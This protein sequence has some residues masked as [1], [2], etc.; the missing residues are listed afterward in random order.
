MP[1][2][3]FEPTI[4]A[5][6][7]SQTYA[8]DRAATGTG[9]IRQIWSKISGILEDKILVICTG[10]DKINTREPAYSGTARDRKLFRC[11]RGTFRKRTCSLDLYTTPDIQDSIRFRLRQVFHWGISGIRSCVAEL[12][13]SVF[14]NYTLRKIPKE[15]RSRVF[16]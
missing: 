2:V 9:L 1:P 14:W 15:H 11:R 7:R 4:S 3:G 10:N 5:G 6:E 13:C 8:L 12:F 16:R